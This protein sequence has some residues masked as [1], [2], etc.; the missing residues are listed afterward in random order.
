MHRYFCKTLKLWRGSPLNFMLILQR[1]AFAASP[2]H[3][4]V[5]CNSVGEFS[6]KHTSNSAVATFR[7]LQS[8]KKLYV[9]ERDHF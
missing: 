4:S 8:C 3:N 6:K 1:L 7:I 9:C 2:L 5:I